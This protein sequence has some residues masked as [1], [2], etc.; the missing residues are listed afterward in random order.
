VKLFPYHDAAGEFYPE[1]DT[2]ELGVDV[3]TQYLSL[4]RIT[5][6]KRALR[7]DYGNSPATG[8]WF[9]V[10]KG[11]RRKCWTFRPAVLWRVKGWGRYAQVGFRA[12]DLEGRIR[13]FHCDPAITAAREQA[14]PTIPAEFADLTRQMAGCN[15][16]LMALLRSMG[17]V[18][19]DPIAFPQEAQQ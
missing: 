16:G 9:G 1:L 13:V 11:G 7:G 8:A 4:S 18:A 3:M 19:N 14:Q 17:R 2:R 5:I 10:P 6:W 12:L 15:M